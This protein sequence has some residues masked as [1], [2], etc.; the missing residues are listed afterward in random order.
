MGPDKSFKEIV[1]NFTPN[2]F[3]MNMGTGILFLSLQGS[4]PSVLPGQDWLT[5]GLWWFDMGLFVLFTGLLLTRFIWFKDSSGRLLRHPVQSMFL[6]AIPM[7]W[8][9]ILDGWLLFG[10]QL[11]GHFAVSLA[12]VLCGGWMP[13]SPC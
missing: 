12:E 7:G 8:V 2:W 1:R 10:P 4:F 6:G 5:Q 9:P 3:T 11:I 13:F